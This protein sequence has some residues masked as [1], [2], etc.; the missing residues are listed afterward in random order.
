VE[1]LIGAM[2]LV[3]VAAQPEAVEAIAEQ[4]GVDVTD[5]QGAVNST[6]LDP[7]TYLQ[8]TGE[9][10]LPV[11]TYGIWD[12]LAACESQGNWGANTG[13]GFY[14]G[15]QF[16]LSTWRANGGSGMPHQA[17]RSEQIRVATIVQARYGWGQWP[18]CSR[19]LGLR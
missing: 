7:K 4:A 12:R 8:M 19:R 9:L 16:L 13:N 1:A 17:S 10:P 5:L 11:P 14:G 15:L 6:G 18:A 3:L 2:A